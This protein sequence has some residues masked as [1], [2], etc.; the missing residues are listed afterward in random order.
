MRWIWAL[1][2]LS[3]RAEN[4]SSLPGVSPRNSG[5]VIRNWQLRGTTSTAKSKWIPKIQHLPGQI[6]LSF[7]KWPLFAQ[8]CVIISAVLRVSW[9]GIP[10]LNQS[11]RCCIPVTPV[12]VSRFTLCQQVD[13]DANTK[14]RKEEEPSY[15]FWI[16]RKV[17]REAHFTA[18]YMKFIVP[19]RW[20]NGG[21]RI[22]QRK[23]VPRRPQG[24]LKDLARDEGGAQVDFVRRLEVRGIG[25]GRVW[26]F[27]QFLFHI[28][29]T[30]NSWIQA[31]PFTVTPQWQAK[32]VSVSHMRGH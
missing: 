4:T 25:R 19:F 8:T 21:Q 29:H 32:S 28:V 13:L 30:P 26:F 9:F 16:R 7:A 22:L 17:S 24:G 18:W 2:Q 10:A 23:W 3:A 20:Q 6:L 5:V 14:R 11:T 15:K 1:A 12:P 27:N 31:W